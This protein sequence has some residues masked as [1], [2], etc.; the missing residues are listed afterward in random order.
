MPRAPKYASRPDPFRSFA[1]DDQ[2]V[3]TIG[4]TTRKAS[5]PGLLYP[6]IAVPDSAF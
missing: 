1:P 4:A 3:M 5:L 2:Q 6:L